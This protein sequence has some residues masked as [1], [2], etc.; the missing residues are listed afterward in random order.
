M[1]LGIVYKIG[2]PTLSDRLILQFI[3]TYDIAKKLL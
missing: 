1:H 2:T 3:A